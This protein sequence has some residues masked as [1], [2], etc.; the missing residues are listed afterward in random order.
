M[1]LLTP[2]FGLIIWT[3]LAFLIVFFLLKKFA[4]PMITSLA[5]KIFFSFTGS[6]DSLGWAKEGFENINK[7]RLKTATSNDLMLLD[8]IFCLNFGAKIRWEGEI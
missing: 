7:P 2:A 6:F 1:Q 5:S 8:L 4:W 3:L